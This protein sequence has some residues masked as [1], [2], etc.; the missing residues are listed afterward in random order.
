MVLIAQD[1]IAHQSAT[2][3]RSRLQQQ[4]Q[5]QQQQTSPSQGQG[6]CKLYM[7][8]LATDV[9]EEDL[10]TFFTEN[11][12]A[13]SSVV[14]TVAKKGFAFIEFINQTAADMALEKCNGK[15]LMNTLVRLEPAIRNEFQYANNQYKAKRF[16]QLLFSNCKY[17]Y[18]TSVAFYFMI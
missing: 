6:C 15:P 12:I 8:N 13:P 18:C 2:V 7:G 4:Q 5:Q 16:I 9:S 3:I 17:Y 10:R 11:N 14:K 1:A